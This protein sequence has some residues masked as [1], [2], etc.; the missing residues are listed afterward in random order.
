MDAQPSPRADGD[1]PPAE[2]VAAPPAAAPAAAAP[3]LPPSAAAVLAAA[4]A[5][6]GAVTRGKRS[7]R[8][9]QRAAPMAAFNGL[10]QA[11]AR[12]DM[13]PKSRVTSWGRVTFSR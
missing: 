1:A 11:R 7:A 10:V 2:A 3:S 5:P 9:A 4:A 13:P 8:Q 12:P 6:A